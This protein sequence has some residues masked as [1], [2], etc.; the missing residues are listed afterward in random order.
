M[1]SNI[2]AWEDF[3]RALVEYRDTEFLGRSPTAGE[4]A[5]LSLAAELADVPIAERAAHAAAI[6]LFLN[7][8][9]CRFP[10]EESALAIAGWLERERGALESRLGLSVLSEQV[11]ELTEE[12]DRLHDSLIDLRQGDPRI[13][14]MSDACASKLLGQMVPALFVMWDQKIRIG[15]ASYG[16]FMTEMH[17]L[18]HRLQDELSPPEARADLE[19]YLQQMLGYPARK[20]LAKYIDEY[21]WWRAWGLGTSS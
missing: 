20:P 2:V 1:D 21:N 10:R 9:N 11:P 12:F 17:Q 6:V 14:T 4:N 18:A 8:W 15:F 7:R 13:F 16:A 3:E 19:G 5:Y